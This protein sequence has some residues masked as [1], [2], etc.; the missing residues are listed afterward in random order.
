MAEKLGA[1][2]VENVKAKVAEL[3]AKRLNE[4]EHAFTF[5][6]LVIIAFKD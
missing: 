5:E 2:N 6:A 4:L 3:A 1:E